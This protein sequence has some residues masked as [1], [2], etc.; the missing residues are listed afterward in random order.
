MNCHGGLD[1]TSEAHPG[2]DQIEPMQG[3]DFA[4]FNAQCQ[5]CH[6]GLPGW[7]QPGAPV[8]FVG[9]SDE[10]LCLQMKQFERTGEKFVEHIDNDHGEIQ[11]IA[12]AFAGDRAL[13]E[14]LR[15]YGLKVE[16]PPGTQAELTAKAR[17]WVEHLGEAYSASKECGCVVKLEGSF[18]QFGQMSETGFN[19][20][21]SMSANY[22]ITGRLVWSPEQGASRARTFGDVASTFLVPSGGEINVEL[23]STGRSE[24]G[25]C[26]VEGSKTFQITELPPMA[27]NYLTLE[28]AADGRYR[29]MLGMVSKYL[30]FQAKRNCSVRAAPGF[31]V[32][33]P[34][35]DGPQIVN[36][37][38]IVI[39]KQ[40]GRVTDEGVVGQTPAPI[41]F[42]VHRYTGTWA[43]K[44]AE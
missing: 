23:E 22:R 33:L 4:A 32:A 28:L 19:Y 1:P 20:A 27:L 21:T 7:R 3:S 42:G 40:E 34:G 38:G 43:F 30:E 36:S 35:A 14:G 26:A 10:E 39:G 41:V 18:S 5:M 24:A 9:K 29:L 37:A 16:P 6:D 15:D 2:A 12:A 25:K 31:P 11:F 17:N 44:A 13:G 8:F